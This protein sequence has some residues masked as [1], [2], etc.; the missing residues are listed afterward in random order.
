MSKSIIR[1][2]NHIQIFNS[3][4]L[5]ER[6]ILYTRDNNEEIRKNFAQAIGSILTNR[7]NSSIQNKLFQDDIPTDLT[8][9]IK[10]IMDNLVLVLNEALDTSNQSLHQT[11]LLTAKNAAW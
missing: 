3:N 10:M 5:A 2:S 7:I 4:S 1:L 11:L 6:W 8:E 9:F